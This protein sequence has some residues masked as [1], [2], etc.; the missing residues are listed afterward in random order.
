VLGFLSLLNVHQSRNLVCTSIGT[1]EAAC[2]SAVHRGR[3]VLITMSAALAVLCVTKEV[4]AADPGSGAGA[5]QLQA[6]SWLQLKQ[7]QKTFRE[8]VEPLEPQQAKRLDRLELR[9]QGRARELEQR[10][11]QYPN[12]ERNIPRR[13]DPWSPST[14]PRDTPS[15]RAIESQRLRM[16]IQR[17]TLRPGLR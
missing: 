1:S 10:R 14:R 13:N 2:T 17:E 4:A 15:R 5:H 9:Q 8:G 11:R 6:E 12:L 3:R 16:R 7:D